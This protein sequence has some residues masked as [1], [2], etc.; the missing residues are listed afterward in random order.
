MQDLG[1]DVSRETY[2]LLDV[3]ASLLLSGILRLT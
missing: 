3:Y 2:D 1:F